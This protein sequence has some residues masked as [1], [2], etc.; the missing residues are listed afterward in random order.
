MATFKAED[1]VR[2]VCPVSVHHGKEA[3]VLRECDGCHIVDKTGRGKWVGLHYDVSVD[4]VGPRGYLN[5]QIAFE[6]HEL[7]PLTPP[8]VDTW[9]ADK[10]RQVTKPIHTEP[11]SVVP[12]W[13]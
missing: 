1:R 9:A 12:V 6:P 2:I 10:V 3:T 11:A 4:G 8:A 5:R 7:Q 13:P